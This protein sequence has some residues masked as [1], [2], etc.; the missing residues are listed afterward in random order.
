M[1][2]A[3]LPWRWGATD[4]EHARAYPADALLT[5][6]VARMTRAVTAAAPPDLAWRWLCQLAL[7]PYSYDWI[8]N[9]GRRSPRALVPG[10]E[11]LEVG[12]VMATVF[13]LTEV[14]EGRAWTARTSPSAERVA[15]PWGVTYAVE[16]LPAIGPGGPERCRLVARIAVP[17]RT[18]LQRARALAVAWGDLVMMRKQLLTLRDLAER[19]ARD[20]R[21]GAAGRVG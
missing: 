14:D 16:P 18:R 12:Q 1:P 8:D 2:E 15:G 10:T 17:S 11:R 19:D 21:P 13:R 4:E 6:P 3:G 5:A 7:A 9:R 20:A